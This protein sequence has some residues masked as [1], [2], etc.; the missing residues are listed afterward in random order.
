MSD[1]EQPAPAE[2]AEV[3]LEGPHGDGKSAEPVSAKEAIEQPA[4]VMRVGTMMKQL[5]DEVRQANL[6]EA[7]RDRCGRSMPLLS[8]NWDRRCPPT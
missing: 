4:K 5:L 7:S 2:P 1:I 8:R 3:V 6:D